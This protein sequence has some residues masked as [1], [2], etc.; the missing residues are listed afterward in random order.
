ML[1]ARR[2]NICMKK[3]DEK[4]DKLMER[5]FIS[6]SLNYEDNIRDIKKTIYETNNKHKKRNRNSMLR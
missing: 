3:F 4:F 1:W 2:I 5:V 6:S